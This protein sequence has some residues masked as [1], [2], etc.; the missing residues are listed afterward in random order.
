MKQN[1]VEQIGV[2]LLKKGFTVKALTRTCFDL[3]ARKDTQVMLVKVLEDANSV[4][5]EYAEEMKKLSSYLNAPSIIIAEKAG[6]ALEDNV[7]YS[8]FDVYTLNTNTFAGCLENRFPFVK[9]SQAGLTV[10]VNGEKLRQAIEQQGHSLTTLARI[11]GVSSRMIQKYEAGQAEVSFNKAISMYKVFGDN[12]FNKINIFSERKE[13][14]AYQSKSEI[15]KKY[16]ELGFEAAETKKVPFD[17][18]A[19]KEKEI[20]LTEVGDKTSPQLQPL[21]KLLEADNL[22]IFKNKKPKDMPA[23]TR[24]EFLDFEKARELIKFLKEFQ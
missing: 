17:V 3:I 1:L 4:S 8:R 18:I 15:T 21:T 12:V 7:V 23:L 24:K 10:S 9:R 6:A 22:V 13:E 11:I 16:D 14:A 2:M 5:P 20:I 19:K